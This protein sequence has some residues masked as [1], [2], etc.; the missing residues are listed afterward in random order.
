MAWEPYT[1]PVVDMDGPH[2]H[3]WFTVRSERGK[4]VSRPA[5]RGYPNRDWAHK[6]AKA[7]KADDPNI[8]DVTIRK[9]AGGAACPIMAGTDAE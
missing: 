4:L 2:F 6:Q 7:V 1:G 9:C 8:L 5:M 3:S